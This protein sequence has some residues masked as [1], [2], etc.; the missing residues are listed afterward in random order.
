MPPPAAASPTQFLANGSLIGNATTPPYSIVWTNAA[1][2]TDALT[3]VAF[4]THGLSSTSAVVNIIV[5]TNDAPA[6][7]ISSP[8]NGSSFLAAT[9]ISVVATATDGQGVATVAIYTNGT[10][11]AQT[12]A[13]PYTFAWNGVAAGS[14][15]LQAVATDIYG[16]AATSAVV[17]ITVT[18]DAPP[19]VAITAPTNNAVFNTPANI[20]FNVA[21]GDID[22]TVSKVEFFTSGAKVGENAIPPF[23]FTWS[24][25]LTTGSIP[26]YAVATDNLGFRGTSAVVTITITAL[27]SPQW[28]AFNDQNQGPASSPNDTFYTAAIFGTS[29][30]ALKDSYTGALLPVT[31]TVTNIPGIANAATMSAPASGTPAYNTFNAYIDW[32]SG[33]GMTVPNSINL[34]PTN[35]I[36]YR[37][38][39]LNPNK[40]YNFVGTAIRGSTTATPG[41]EY[42]NRW[43][44]AELVGALSYLP[45][46]S[47]NVITAA[48]FPGGLT[49]SQAAWNAG[50]NN[51]ATTGDIVEWDNISPAADGSF[52][53]LCSKYTGS[54]PGGS[55]GN[56]LYSYA[57]SAMKLGLTPFGITSQPQSL[58]ITPGDTAT[59]T[60]TAVAG[61]PRS[62]ING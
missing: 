40:Q 23:S 7:A 42:S 20:T 41:N 38:T 60:V 35:T 1:Y 49:G 45:A 18:N 51:T 50:I 30:G 2:G 55:A 32:N 17:N 52:T 29:T 46:H 14:Y 8:A 24:N 61:T 21:A 44:Q 27:V 12:V 4:D 5:R 53:I 62:S 37:F 34:Y 25:V 16:L 9:N 59:F 48:Q 19:A 36:G 26:A 22:G 10:K 54:I 13:S 57:F 3:A 47:S 33:T 43:T 6:V 31:L 58:T 15:Q 28:N 11:L 56:S 39:G